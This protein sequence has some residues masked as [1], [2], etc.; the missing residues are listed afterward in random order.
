MRFFPL[1]LLLP[2]AGAQAAP[3]GL[4][5][6]DGTALRDDKGSVVQLRGVNLGGWLEWQRWMCPINS[7]DTPALR[8]LNPGHNGYDFPQSALHADPQTAA[9]MSARSSVRMPPPMKLCTPAMRASRS[10]AALSARCARTSFTRR[11]EP[12]CS[13]S[14]LRASVIPSV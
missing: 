11:S 9:T 10:P 3:A 4:L 2:L 8:D 7:S 6:T 14:G 1:L 13:R 12:N 5:H